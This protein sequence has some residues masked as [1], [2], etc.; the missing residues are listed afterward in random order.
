M[1]AFSTPIYVG[2]HRHNLDGKNRLTMPSKWRFA[3]D[4]ADVY[5]AVP[6][7]DGYISVLPPEETKRLHEKMKEVKMSDRSGQDFVNRFFSDAHAFGCDKQGRFTLTPGL[8]NH[9]AIG[10]EVVLVGNMI[11][12]AIWNPQ[13]WEE[14][15]GRTSGEA[16]GELMRRLDF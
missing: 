9:A 1:T 8:W 15:H 7:P 4:E 13:K 12:F 5:L 14:V 11:R 3:G 6:H 10:K 16:F 2:S